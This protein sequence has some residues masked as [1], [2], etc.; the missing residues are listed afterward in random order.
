[1]GA[2][3]GRP[4]EAGQ[5][6]V[7]QAVAASRWLYTARDSGYDRDPQRAAPFPNPQ[8]FPMTPH[9]KLLLI[10]LLLL[11]AALPSARAQEFAAPLGKLELQ[12]GDSIVFLGDSITHQ[13]LYTQYVEDFFYTRYP[14][15][16]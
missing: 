10:V 14:Q 11:T 15:M 1:T 5:D 16:R 13:R 8:E 4:S 7:T 3:I 12:D 9:C 6:G 2:S